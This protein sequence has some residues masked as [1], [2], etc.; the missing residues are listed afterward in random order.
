MRTTLSLD[1][2][3]LLA[4]K[5]RARREKRTAGEVLSDLARQ[6]LQQQNA[7]PGPTAGS[8]HGFE[9]FGHRGPAI[10]NA[11]VDKLREEE[12]V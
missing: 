9:P 10:S 5:E 2:D 12:A 8:F 11:L 7:E 4:V 1:D 3:V 6:A